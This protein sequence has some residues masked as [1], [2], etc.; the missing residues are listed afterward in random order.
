L[1]D[2]VI[3]IV[4]KSTDHLLCP[5]KNGYVR[6]YVCCCTIDTGVFII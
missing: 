4:N 1:Q 6:A 2:D 3:V 5:M